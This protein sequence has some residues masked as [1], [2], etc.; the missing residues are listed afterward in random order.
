VDSFEEVMLSIQRAIGL[1]LI[2]A[3]SSFLRAFEA[4]HAGYNCENCYHLLGMDVIFDSDM[5][6]KVVEVNGE[7]SLRMTSSGKTHYDVTKKSMAKDMIGIVYN[8]RS[9]ATEEFIKRFVSWGQCAS[10]AARKGSSSESQ[11]ASDTGGSGGA[12]GLRHASKGIKSAKVGRDHLEYLLSTF[13]EH[14]SMG[15]FLPVY[16]NPRLAKSYKTFLELLHVKESTAAAARAQSGKPAR[17]SSH[18]DGRRLKLHELVTLLQDQEQP[19]G[20]EMFLPKNKANRGTNK[21][22]LSSETK[23]HGNA[24]DANNDEEEDDD[25]DDEE[26]EG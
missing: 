4:V 13:R 2:A 14:E 19:A 9:A 23:G 10:R 16:P 8:Q 22:N 1:T 6:P 3:E 26:D 11:P 17:V 21:D 25:D 5:Q 24:R 7:P 20:D 12:S 15:G 18:A